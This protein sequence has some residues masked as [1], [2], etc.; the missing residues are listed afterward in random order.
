MKELTLS[1]QLLVC[2]ENGLSWLQN[3]SASRVMVITG[4]SS[5]FRTG[6]IE[7]IKEILQ[8]GKNEVSV[9]SG[10]GKNPTDMQVAAGLKEMKQFLPEIVLAVGGGSPIDAAK[11]MV[12]FYENPQLNFSNV[13][14][15]SLEDI[16]L[17]TRLIAIP[18]TSGTA[19]E[20]THVSVITMSG[21]REKKAIKTPALRP[22]AAIL[23]PA[24]PMTLPAGIAAET[25]MDALTH[26]LEA[27]ISKNG[28]DFTD[29]LAKAAIEGLMEWLPFSVMS[30]DR[31]SREKIH[32]FQCMAGM[33]FANSGLG[34]VHGVSH[35]FGG[36][37]DLAH[38]LANA[39]ILPY[40][41]DYNRKDEDVAAKY[42]ILSR[43]LG[44]DVIE[45]VRKLQ[46]ILSIPESFWAAGISEEDYKRDYEKICAYAMKGSTKVNPIPV[47][48]ED[49]RK[50][51]DCVYYGH[52]VTF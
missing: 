31:E 4:G 52:R 11:A 12:L 49:M 36:I 23:D 3:I 8:Q 14:S 32:N 33:A 39:V 47:S 40:S 26:A 16:V 44:K 19:S 48:T 20:V 21:T 17:K 30:P 46:K 9:Y 22:D 50:F 7:K 51:V 1:G 41:M 28:N 25:G 13:F 10:I 6:V 5:M 45:K 35:A 27:Y 15:A 38:G 37:Y 43:M 24:L 34:M 29:A 18:S 2:G 42:E